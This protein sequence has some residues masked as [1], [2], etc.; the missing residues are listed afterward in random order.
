MK[1]SEIL[2]L[3][4]AQLHTRA[5]EDPE[6]VSEL[7]AQT[8]ALLR[9]AHDHLLLVGRSTARASGQARVTS[10]GEI[11]CKLYHCAIGSISSRCCCL[12]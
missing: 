5:T 11:A 9:R 3:S 4:V 6:T 8:V 1:D 2:V 10:R 7:L 12:A